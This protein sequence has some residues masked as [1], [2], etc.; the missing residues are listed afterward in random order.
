VT[1]WP[2]DDGVGIG[3]DGVG[4]V[5]GIVAAAA[6]GVVGGGQCVLDVALGGVAGAHPVVDGPEDRGVGI[7]VAEVAVEDDLG[8]AGLG[9]RAG[10]DGVE[11]VRVAVHPPGDVEGCAAERERP[12]QAFGP[13]AIGD[14]TG[15]SKDAH[16]ASNPVPRRR[17]CIDE[18]V[19]VSSAGALRWGL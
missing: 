3:D 17:R 11:R 12:G 2:G 6:E 1:I 10:L 13:V 16:V 5:A 9:T 15:R 7:E 14:R 4:H 8:R 19:M 18:L